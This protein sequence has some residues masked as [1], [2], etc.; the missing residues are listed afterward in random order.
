M[1]N[2]RKFFVLAALSAGLITSC[3][4]D[5]DSTPDVVIEEEL[6]TD[7]TITLTADGADPVTLT[8]VDPDGADGATPPTIETSGPLKANT[9]YAGSFEILNTSEEEAE[10]VTEEIKELAAEHQF[11]FVANDVAITTTY[12]D[13]ECDYKKP[14]EECDATTANP[15]GL[16]FELATAD[17]GTGTLTVFLKHEPNKDAEGVADGDVTN[18]GGE[19]DIDVTFDVT[20][21]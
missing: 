6:I 17:A 20:V 15:V 2:T 21:E 11:F 16:S 19:N 12:T 9:T 18:A 5:D 4:D 8:V 13:N 1:M 10:D 7:V 3:S 14:D